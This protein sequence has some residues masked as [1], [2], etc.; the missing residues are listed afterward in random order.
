MANT[1]NLQPLVHLAKQKNDAATR[2]LGLLNQQQQSAQGKL[3]TLQQFRKDY[4]NQFQAAA[5][6]GMDQHDLRNFQSFINRLDEA[7]T[8][9]RTVIE[10]AQR[11]VQTGRSELSEAQ[12][13]MKSFDTLAQRHVAAER[14]LE[15]K[16]EQKIQDEHSGRFVA[17]KMSEKNDES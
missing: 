2:K 4:Q 17:Y 1:F 14:R 7:I 11:S 3:D 10:Q 13:R 8:Q 15:D 6:N 12:R 9:Q 5:K 16:A